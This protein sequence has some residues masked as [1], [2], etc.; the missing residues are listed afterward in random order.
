[1]RVTV[2]RTIAAD[3]LT[4]VSAFLTIADR[5][6]HSFLLESVEGGEHLGRYTFLGANPYMVLSARGNDL[7][8]TRGRKTEM[9]TADLLPTLKQIFAENHVAPAPGLPPFTSGAVGYLA[10]DFVRNLERLPSRAK[11]DI[12]VPDCTLMFFDRVLAFDHVRHELHLIATCAPQ[13]KKAAERDLAAMERKLRGGI[14]PSVRR[15][16]QPV[17]GKLKVTPTT[18]KAKFLRDVARIKDYITAGDVFQ[19]VLSQRLEFQPGV[20]PFEV[21]RALRRVNPSPYMYYLRMGPD[22]IAGSS[23]EMLVKASSGMLNYRPIAGTRWRGATEAED[24]Q[25]ERDL[26]ADE[27]ERA[28]HVMLVDLG[29]NDL[30]RVSQ[31]GSVRVKDLMYVERYSHVMHLV[32]ALEGKLRPELTPLDAFAAC[33]PAGTLTGAPKVRAMQ[34]I[35]ELE[36]V[37]RGVYGGSVFYA[38]FAGNLDSCIAI[39]TMFMRGKHAYVQAGAGIV[40]DSVPE[41]EY[42]ECLNK[43]KALLR[44]VEKARGA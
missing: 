15:S 28:E 22:H 33:F 42:E 29:R 43:A 21:Y 32:S 6:E 38:D 14:P 40:A 20:A 17:R 26:L 12:A 44:A 7:A 4:P 16:P 1:M 31:P 37:R 8:I 36:P 24:R 19:A 3:L 9:L 13:D 2:S 34:I 11:A 23:P 30:G 39:R 18:S 10:Y 35:E 5:S 41:R 25:L 27:K